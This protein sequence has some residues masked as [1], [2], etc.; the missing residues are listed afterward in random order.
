MTTTMAAES[1]AQDEDQDQDQV[2]DQDQHQDTDGP[3]RVCILANRYLLG[4]Q[5]EALER[6]VAT[7]D[8]EIPL[9]VVNEAS[10]VGDD[11][12]SEGASARGAQAYDNARGIGRD[13]L[14]LFFELLREEGVYTFVLA[15]K[16]LAWM[17]RG[18]TPALMRRHRVDELAVLDDAAFVTCRPEPV[19]GPWCDLPGAVVDRVV[20]ETDVAVRFGFSL[21]TGRIIAEP[22]YGVLSFH[23]ADIREYRGIGPAQPFLN[24]D[25]RAGATLQQLTDTVDGGNV[26]LIESVDISDA[27]TLDEIR[28]RVNRLQARMLATGVQR[29]QDPEFEPEPP[30]RLGTYLSVTARQS[31]AFAGRVLAKNLWG[32]LRGG[33]A[34]RPLLSALGERL[35]IHAVSR[36]R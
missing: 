20:A 14:A 4:W 28:D 8:V 13:E 6:L 10:A 2:Q 25:D 7:T 17:L 19:D 16:K 12:F 35:P 30:D 1:R 21:L 34:S 36:E 15:E 33:L 11:G 22:A 31:P 24:G 9:V 26:V 27:H 3:R 23:P 29:L 32:R 5:V 18:E